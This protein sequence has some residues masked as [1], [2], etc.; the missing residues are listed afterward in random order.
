MYLD[1]LKF[2][3]P[4]GPLLP[5]L[6]KIRSS[7]P[8]HNTPNTPPP[9]IITILISIFAKTP[10]SV[11]PPSPVGGVGLGGVGLGGVGLGGVGLGGVGLGGVGDGWEKENGKEFK[12]VLDI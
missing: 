1:C 3:L 9:A 7:A 8:R 10:S 11:S 2:G 12:K 5:F 4:T 6:Q